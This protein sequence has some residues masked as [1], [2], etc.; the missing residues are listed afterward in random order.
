MPKRWVNTV[1]PL[2]KQTH[3]RSLKC[4]SGALSSLYSGNKFL[5]ALKEKKYLREDSV[6]VSNDETFFL[7][8]VSL[9]KVNY[10]IHFALH[11]QYLFLF[12]NAILCS[13]VDYKEEILEK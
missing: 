7:L 1:Y 3:F 4:L 5:M 6:S 10:I 2:S 9:F 12:H 13:L 11:F 8:Q